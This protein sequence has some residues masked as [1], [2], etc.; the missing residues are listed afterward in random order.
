MKR[1]SALLFFI[2]LPSAWADNMEAAAQNLSDCVM[3]YADSQTATE[4]AASDIAHAAFERCITE[5]SAMINTIGPDAAQWET[6]DDQQK[7]LITGVRNK[8]RLDIRQA[9]SDEIE[10]FVNAKRNGAS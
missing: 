8:A 4:A 1:L 7:Q 6:L 5:E 3:K 10:N 2:A 9:F